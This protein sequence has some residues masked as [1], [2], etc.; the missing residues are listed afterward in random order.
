[1]NGYLLTN[2]FFEFILFVT[3]QISTAIGHRHCFIC[4]QS[5]LLL[6]C[7]IC[8]KDTILPL[9]PSPGHNLLD[10]DKVYDNLDAP[11]YESLY[12]LGEY[13]GII[14]G[15]INQLKFSNK[16]LAASVLVSFF[17]RYMFARLSLNQAIPEALVPIPLSNA[18][19]IAR[20][21]NQSRLL[22]QKLAKQLD[23]KSLDVLT[24]IKNTKQQSS[25]NK[26]ERA[27]NI[28]DA[29]ILSSKITVGSL[30]IVDDV[31]TT[32]ATVNEACKVIKQAYPDIS[33]S[34]WCMAATIR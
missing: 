34:V 31:I 11:A 12:A 23:I 19:Y 2:K 1:M 3:K 27:H 22:S 8:I 26:E 14:K 30:A 21:Y 10:F 6:V 32:G 17:E 33:V 29:F 28:Q 16:P 5:S 18:R 20:Q 24:R 4:H 7:D 9:F 25:L 15:L 13:N